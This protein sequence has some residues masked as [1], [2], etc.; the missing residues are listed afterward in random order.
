[1]FHTLYVPLKMYGIAEKKKL[2]V[3]GLRKDVDNWN[4]H[5]FLGVESC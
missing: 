2:A 3:P 5:G 1:M 4:S